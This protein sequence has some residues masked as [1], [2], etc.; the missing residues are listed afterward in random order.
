MGRLR[1][2]MCA[3]ARA[4]YRTLVVLLLLITCGWNRNLLIIPYC[5][6]AF[7]AWVGVQN[8]FCWTSINLQ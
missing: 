7:G 8:S 1:L 5:I 2:G 3:R 4:C 6:W